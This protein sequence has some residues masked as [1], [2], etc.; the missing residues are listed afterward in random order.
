MLQGDLSFILAESYMRFTWK[1]TGPAS[2]GT[3]QNRP[4]GVSEYRGG[5]PLKPPPMTQGSSF[6]MARRAYAE[7]KRWGQVAARGAQPPVGGGQDECQGGRAATGC[8][9]GSTGPSCRLLEACCYNPAALEPGHDPELEYLKCSDC[10]IGGA[11]HS[12]CVEGHGYSIC[13]CEQPSASPSASPLASP[14]ASP[15]ASPQ[16][17][18]LASPQASPLASPQ[19][20]PQGS[21]LAGEFDWGAS[22]LKRGPCMNGRG[23]G[24]S[25][26][27]RRGH[28]CARGQPLVGEFDY[29]SKT[30]L[31]AAAGASDRTAR[32]KARAIGKSS[33]GAEGK[34]M[35]FKAFDRNTVNHRRQKTRAGGA[36]APK[37]KGAI[38]NPN[39]SGGCC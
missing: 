12:S 25:V 26:D 30:R 35:S 39:G 10:P 29:R 22:A 17:S 20:S 6:A 38:A 14:Q 32:M 5:M 3:K 33:V 28:G 36:V 2:F 37:K 1:T 23:T 16:A 21:P 9:P 7:E 15:L 8:E 19:A 34:P 13:Q 24:G 31:L 11:A 18:P 4:N 27:A